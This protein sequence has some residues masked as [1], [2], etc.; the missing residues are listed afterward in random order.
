MKIEYFVQA[1]NQSLRR[2]GESVEYMELYSNINKMEQH[3]IMQAIL[4]LSERIILIEAYMDGRKEFHLE[5]NGKVKK[6]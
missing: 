5:Y 6:H 4:E 1:M 2:V 3:Q